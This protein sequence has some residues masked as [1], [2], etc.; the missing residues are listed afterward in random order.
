MDPAILEPHPELALGLIVTLGIGAQWAAWRLGLPSILLLLAAGLAVGPVGLGLIDP[1]ALLPA[2]VLFTVVSAAVAVI[3]FEGGLTLRLRELGHGGA[4]LRR[5]LWLGVPLA[6]L[7]GAGAYGWFYG[8]PVELA[9]S[10]GAILVVTGP[11]VIGPLLAQVKPS[12]RAGTIA[13]WEG[14][15][16][17]PI[18]AVL[19]VLMLEVVLARGQLAAWGS[20]ALGLAVAA[21]I[22]VVG[23]LLCAWLT[24]TAMRRGWLPDHLHGVGT[25]ALV[26]VLAIGCNQIQ[27]ESGLLAVTVYGAG[28]ANQRRV[29]VR[30]VTAFNEHLRTLLIALLF[31]VLAARF[32]PVQL[33][34][35]DWR[36]AAFLGLLV[37][38]VRP[39]C[40]AAACA[41]TDLPWRDRALLAWMAP[42]GIVAA[43]VASLFALKLDAAGL[44]GG[45]VIE[46]LL[47]AVIVGTVLIYG[48]GAGPLASL[49]GQR[50][51]ARGGLLLIGAQP[52][53]RALATAVRDAGYPVLLIDSD[54]EK[55]RAARME[56]LEVRNYSVMEARAD[57]DGDLPPGID[58]ML[59]LTP[60]DE[61]NALAALRFAH[62]IGRDGVYQLDAED[63]DLGSRELSNHLSGHPVLGGGIGYRELERRFGA[64]AEAKVTTLTESYGLADYRREDRDALPLLV[65]RAGGRLEVLAEA[66]PEI[67]DGDRLVALVAPSAGGD[68]VARAG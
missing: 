25:L 1:R 41:V 33:T 2:E 10:V 29:S 23:G 5:L 59:A 38:A 65:L 16:N 14:I 35:L 11:T 36:A 18:G 63:G 28:L 34:S 46:P 45:E 32:T 50:A 21:V 27:A 44:D 51:G 49:L 58:R 15:L 8:G 39:L 68:D 40:V 52:W 64:A 43:A 7:L 17:D 4:P 37:L 6:W 55:V 47:Y 67:Y 3:L 48:L 31:I 9:L 13:K 42:R 24:V 53:A 22:G 54:R 19:A 12:G 62:V 20:V 57:D 61:A 26:L 56:G 60:S 30:H 66:D